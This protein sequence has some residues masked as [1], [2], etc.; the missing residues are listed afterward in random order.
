MDV[1]ERQY[2]LH[3]QR[4]QRQA[5]AQVQ[6]RSEPAHLYVRTSPARRYQAASVPSGDSIASLQRD[7]AVK[8]SYGGKLWRLRPAH[9]PPTPELPRS[10]HVAIST[11]A[12]DAGFGD[13]SYSNRCFRGQYGRTPREVRGDGDR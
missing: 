2:H 13:L 3:R 8:S 4:E 11:I 10:S 6:I 9:A 7:A 5:R 12:Y 1:P